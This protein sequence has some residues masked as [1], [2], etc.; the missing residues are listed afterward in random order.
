LKEFNLTTIIIRNPRVAIMGNCFQTH[1][2]STVVD[3]QTS[4]VQLCGVECPGTKSEITGNTKTNI[5]HALWMKEYDESKIPQRYLDKIHSCKNS[6][7]QFAARR[8]GQMQ[9]YLNNP[10]FL[11]PDY[12]ER[13]NTL[14][15]YTNG[16]EL[17]PQQIRYVLYS[18][19]FFLNFLSSYDYDYDYDHDS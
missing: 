3:Q 8:S 17:S 11:N 16:K 14:L 18:L 2:Q 4:D 12:T 13:Y 10:V 15:E 7:Q 19:A 9:N 1:Q 5:A 6:P